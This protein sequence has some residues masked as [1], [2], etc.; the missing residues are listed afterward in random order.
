MTLNRKKVF[1]RGSYT[2]YRNVLESIQIGRAFKLVNHK[3][4]DRASV[5]NDN[6][7]SVLINLLVC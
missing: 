4:E 6:S 7:L 3:H 5:H 1:I 2:L